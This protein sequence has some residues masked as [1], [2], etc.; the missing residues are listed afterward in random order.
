VAFDRWSQRRC[1]A[2]S[3]EPAYDYDASMSSDESDRRLAE[4][5]AAAPALTRRHLQLDEIPLLT[6]HRRQPQQQPLQQQQLQ[7]QQP[8]LDWR[9]VVERARSMQQQAVSGREMLTDK[10][11]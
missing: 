4:M 8:L 5:H 1:Y 6:V 9:E 11:G 2:A 7:Q 3:A 10:F